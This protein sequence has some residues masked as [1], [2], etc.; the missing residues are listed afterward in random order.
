MQKVDESF[1]EDI[2]RQVFSQGAV[3]HASGDEGVHPVEIEFIKLG[4]TAMDPF[5]QPPPGD[6][7]LSRG[8]VTAIKLGK[9]APLEDSRRCA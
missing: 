5:A 8:S 2:R 4:K 6:V 3:P 1:V 7:V 9:N